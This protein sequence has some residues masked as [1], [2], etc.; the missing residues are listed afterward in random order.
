MINVRFSLAHPRE[1]CYG[2]MV[3]GLKMFYGID[4]EAGGV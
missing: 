3:K 1:S 4:G 2:G